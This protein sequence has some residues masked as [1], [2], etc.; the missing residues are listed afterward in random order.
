MGITLQ[1][2]QFS[3]VFIDPEI[4]DRLYTLNLVQGVHVRDEKIIYDQEVEYR[5]WNPFHSKLAA[6]I[7]RGIQEMP[8]QPHQTGLYLGASSGTTVSHVS[9]I[10]GEGV[11]YALEFAPRSLREL[12]QN[13]D[14]RFNVVPI[15][16][17][18]T[19]PAQYRQN[20][21]GLVDFLYEDVA[22]PTQSKILVDN[23][24]FF[25][26]DGGLC[27]LAIKSRSIDVAED[28]KKIFQQ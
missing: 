25:L 21:L 2:H 17:D 15:L 7:L 19:R 8:V 4:P 26:K 18:A 13:C 11:V 28:P 3:G 12:I 24:K 6:A 23:A 5:E 16:G 22:Q 10:I 14:Q 9:D 1:P 27:F 20:V